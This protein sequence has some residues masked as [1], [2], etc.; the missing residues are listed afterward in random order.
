MVV[1]VGGD[2]EQVV[3]AGVGRLGGSGKDRCPDL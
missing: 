2:G 1:R 3:T